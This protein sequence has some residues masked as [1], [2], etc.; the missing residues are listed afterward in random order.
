MRECSPCES[1]MTLLRHTLATVAYRGGK[2]LRGAPPE[3]SSFQGAAPQTPGR[4]LAH[5]CDLFDWAT[6]LADGAQAWRNS[7][8]Q[9]WDEDSARFF[10]CLDTLDCRIASGTPLACT[11]EALFQGPIADALTH[12]GQL[13]AMRRRAGAPIAAASY[14]K[15]DIQAGRTA[16]RDQSD[17]VG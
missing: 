8:P 7:T 11:A 15:A 13:H 6:T 12:V 1:F 17:V 3:F 16:L 9:S 10:A 14:V 5:I 2:A 4:I